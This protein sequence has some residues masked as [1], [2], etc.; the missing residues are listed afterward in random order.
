M[1]HSNSEA[2]CW[3]YPGLSCFSISWLYSSFVFM[4]DAVCLYPLF[5]MPRPLLH[6]ISLALGLIGSQRGWRLSIQSH[7]L[8]LNCYAALMRGIGRMWRAPVWIFVHR[9]T[10]S[11][12]LRGSMSRLGWREPLDRGKCKC[13]RTFRQVKAPPRPGPEIVF[14]TDQNEGGECRSEGNPV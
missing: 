1:G 3:S 7:E 14:R 12:R 5:S 13:R 2:W 8:C 6:S 10:C 11:M 4:K 9:R